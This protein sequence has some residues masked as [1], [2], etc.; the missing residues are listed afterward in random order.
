MEFLAA[1]YANKLIRAG[2]CDEPVV[3]GLDHELAW[4]REHE[5]TPLLADVFEQINI[6]GLIFG[7]PAEPFA[8]VVDFLARQYPQGFCPR[9]TET[10]T[11]LHH[12][13]VIPKLTAKGVAGALAHRKSVIVPEVGIA[14]HGSVSLE[15]A[16]VTF[17]SVCFSSFVLFFA[18]YLRHARA[19]TVS[20]ERRTAFER[21]VA[22]LEPVQTQ[23]PNLASG[24]FGEHEPA[25]A[26]MAQAGRATVDYRLVDS[27]FG[28]VSCLMDDT[29]LISQTGSSLDELEGLIDLCPLDGSSTACLTASS[30]LTAHAQVYAQT[31]GRT[32]LHGHPRFT[33]ILSMDCPELYGSNACDVGREDMCHLK[34][35]KERHLPGNVP[36]VPGEV[37]T[38][39]HGLANTL[40]A[41]MKQRG[42]TAVWGHGLFTMGHTDFNE[43]FKALLEI[44][45]DCREEYFK[46]VQL[47]EH[48]A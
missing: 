20:Q 45:N 6:S 30:E 40:P 9:D 44:E 34:C 39:P 25:M 19:G 14:T 10:R 31:Q 47:G 35:P 29:L 24:A 7:R 27:Y 33:V 43:P 23:L 2:L 32:I 48:Q 5:L 22:H 11:F 46:R 41:A 42:A 26:A 17:S 15:Q 8:T 4:N 1:K 3:A 21:A 13:P 12:L 38:G 28:N 18:E 36:I 37:G 16:F